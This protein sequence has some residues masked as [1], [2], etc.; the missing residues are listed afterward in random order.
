MSIKQKILAVALGAIL[1]A[2]AVAIP[3]GYVANIVKLCGCD[4]QA[5]YKAEV[6]RGVGVVVPVVGVPAGY[7]DLGK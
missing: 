5:P 2:G 7:M 3:V 1:V 6:I 4:F